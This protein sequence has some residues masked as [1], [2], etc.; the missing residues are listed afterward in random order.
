MTASD[1]TS[2]MKEGACS[3]SDPELMFP[4]TDEEI[5]LA[6]GVCAT[7]SIQVVCLE[8]ALDN[9]EDYGVWGGASEKERRKIIKDRR[10][11]TEECA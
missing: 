5:A 7:C 4:K 10:Q 2:W 9:R 11:A 1:R 8:Y 3:G 6:V